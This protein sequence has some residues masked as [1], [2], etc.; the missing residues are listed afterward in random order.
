MVKLLLLLPQTHIQVLHSILGLEAVAQHLERLAVEHPLQWHEPSFELVV[1]HSL[2]VFVKCLLIY[3]TNESLKSY[4]GSKLFFIF[5]PAPLGRF[6]VQPPNMP[7]L[8][9]MFSKTTLQYL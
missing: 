3:K 6:S 4:K 2:R 9:G 8:P 7:K 5:M 1:C